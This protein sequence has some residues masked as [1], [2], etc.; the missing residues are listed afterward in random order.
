MGDAQEMVSHSEGHTTYKVRVKS[1][2]HKMNTWE[3]G[4]AIPLKNV[5]VDGIRLHL[6][7]Y[8]NGYKD[9]DFV[10]IF[11]DNISDY[12][13]SI[14]F[15]LSMGDEKMKGC[16]FEIKKKG[17]RGYSNFYSHNRIMSKHD[18]DFEITLTVKK[19]YK[20][21]LADDDDNNN[22]TKSLDRMERKLSSRIEKLEY[23][24]KNLAMRTGGSKIP[25]PECPI[26]FEDITQDSRIMQCSA[27][28]LI[29]GGCHDKLRAKICPTCKKPNIGR[30]HGM[31]SYLKS[32]FPEKKNNNNN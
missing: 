32:L 10:S 30:C 13:I 29:C 28:H 25:Y 16:L 2:K 17:N 22:V 24:I 15:D 18:K 6:D 23:S 31:E 21:V 7:I 19:L 26:C 8:P 4:M 20:E 3:R 1:F 27:G 5:M 14:V 9:E 11:I 12:D